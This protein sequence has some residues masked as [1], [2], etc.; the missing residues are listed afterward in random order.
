M[1][2]QLLPLLVLSV[3]CVFGCRTLDPIMLDRAIV[4]NATPDEITDVSITHQP[5]Q[6][7][8][9][10]SLILPGKTFDLGF[11]QRPLLSD[12]AI[13]TWTQR[14]GR[15]INKDLSLH[16]EAPDQDTP[17]TLIYIIKD[18][19]EVEV[20]LVSDSSIAIQ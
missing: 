3:L 6:I 17:Y 1:K 12:R 18:R 4:M 8:G 13:V 20:K 19:G 14:G 10:A 11:S 9:S 7:T 15:K 5:K 16:F 2:I